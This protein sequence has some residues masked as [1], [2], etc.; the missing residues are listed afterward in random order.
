MAEEARTITKIKKYVSEKGGKTIKITLSETGTP[1]LL[2]AMPDIGMFLV[3]T[4]AKRKKP[5]LIQERR[6]EEWNMS[7]GRAFWC[8]SLD[9][10][11][12]NLK[13]KIL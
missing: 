10:F 7:G 1:D 13:N 9:S 12:D 8:D 5:T 6:M 4:K 11:I 3:E 2:V